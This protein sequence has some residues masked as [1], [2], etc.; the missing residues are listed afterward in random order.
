MRNVFLLSVM[1]ILTFIWVSTAKAQVLVIHHADGKTTDVELLT[2][3]QVKFYNNKVLITS[4]VLK[5]EYPKEDVLTFT[6]KGGSLGINSPQ[7]DHLSFSQ[8]DGKIVF[9]NIKSSEKIA[10]YNTKG[11][12]IPISV[13]RNGEDATLPLSSI[14]SGVYLLNVNGKTSKFTKL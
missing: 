11:V 9:H 5:M 3:P 6:F 7:E 14:P 10:L 12:R 1:W 13:I 4:S 2:Q 8:E